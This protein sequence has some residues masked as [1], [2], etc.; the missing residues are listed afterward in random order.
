MDALDA[1]SYHLVILLFI[2]QWL[3]IS[4]FVLR[5]SLASIS[6]RDCNGGAGLHL[7]RLI[8]RSVYGYLY[9]LAVIAVHFLRA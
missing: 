6:F 7:A 8:F 9:F 1:F 4:L 3:F 5:F 2:I